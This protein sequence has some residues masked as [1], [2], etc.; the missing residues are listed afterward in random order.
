M[1]NQRFNVAAQYGTILY[2]VS[3]MQKSTD[4]FYWRLILESGDKLLVDLAVIVVLIWP[5]LNSSSFIC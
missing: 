4:Y 1:C 5:F 3:L 2:I